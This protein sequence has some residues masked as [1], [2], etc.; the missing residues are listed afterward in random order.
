MWFAI[1]IN[2]I[3]YFRSNCVNYKSYC[4]CSRSLMDRRSINNKTWPMI[5]SLN[6][7]DLKNRLFLCRSGR[8]RWPNFSTG[9]KCSS[10]LQRCGFPLFTVVTCKNTTQYAKVRNDRR[11]RG[12]EIRNTHF[13]K[14][15]EDI[16]IR[17]RIL[18]LD[19]LLFFDSAV[20]FP[21][22]IV[23]DLTVLKAA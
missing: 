8:Y 11:I 12:Q 14:Q 7:W 20:R 19:N 1:E 9:I 2:W 15:L 4:Y 6:T 17:R 22:V 18:L 23:G 5:C 13:L 3:N 10:S 16:I 21:R